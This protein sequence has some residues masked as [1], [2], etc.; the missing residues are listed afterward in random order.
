MR[1]KYKDR[2]CSF[3]TYKSPSRSAAASILRSPR[4]GSDGSREGSI[5]ASSSVSERPACAFSSGIQAILAQAILAQARRD[6][7]VVLVPN[8]ALGALELKAFLA[9]GRDPLDAAIGGDALL[10]AALH[11][12]GVIALLLH[13]LLERAV[14]LARGGRSAH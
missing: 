13:Q 2:L 3:R 7:H 6:F 1:S 8:K 10:E 14:G 9:V 12:L 11:E 4:G 5:V